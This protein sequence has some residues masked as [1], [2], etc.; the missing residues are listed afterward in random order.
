M[1]GHNKSA[2]AVGAR[3]EDG[4]LELESHGFGLQF[5]VELHQVFSQV[6][7]K[8]HNVTVCFRADSNDHDACVPSPLFLFPPDVLMELVVTLIG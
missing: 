3:F 6:L 8:F 1:Y 4:L 2:L 5:G 7:E